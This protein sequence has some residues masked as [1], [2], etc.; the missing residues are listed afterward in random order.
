MMYGAGAIGSPFADQFYMNDLSVIFTAS[1]RFR[2][3]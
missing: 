3:P 1:R 2:L